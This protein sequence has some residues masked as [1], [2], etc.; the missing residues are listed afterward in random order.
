MMKQYVAVQTFLA[1][2]SKKGKKDKGQSLAE[3]GL[4][5]ALVAVFCIVALQT[6]GGSIDS[7]LQNLA[8]EIDS[9]G[10]GG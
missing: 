3:Y 8:S 4:I 7:M 2:R 9:A 1:T 5:L 10:G 6:L